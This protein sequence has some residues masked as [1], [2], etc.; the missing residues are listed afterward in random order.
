MRKHNLIKVM[1]LSAALASFVAKVKPTWAPL[2]FY[3]GS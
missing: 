2:G 1:L 3:D